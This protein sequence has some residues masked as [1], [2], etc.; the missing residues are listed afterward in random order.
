MHCCFFVLYENV[1]V[2]KYGVDRKF[3]RNGRFYSQGFR[4]ISSFEAIYPKH[5]DM[6]EV[7]EWIKSGVKLRWARRFPKT[8]QYIALDAAALSVSILI[9]LCLAPYVRYGEELLFAA[10]ALCL[11]YPFAVLGL[12]RSRA[13]IKEETLRIAEWYA[14]WGRDMIAKVKNGQNLETK[15]PVLGGC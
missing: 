7:K 6:L 8:W 11:Y 15:T 14:K 1:L 2:K 13:S 4:A 5:L 12:K 9:F 10:I 3:L